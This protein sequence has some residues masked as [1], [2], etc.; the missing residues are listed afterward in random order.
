MEASH[1][2]D[3]LVLS[4]EYKE[5]IHMILT[6]V[7]MPGVNGPQLIK[8]C[9]EVRQDFSVIYMSG[10][11]DDVI[12]HHGISKKGINYIQKPFTMDGLAKKVREVLNENLRPSV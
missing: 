1:G 11:T 10:Y 8:Q 2:D 5:P 6:D 12:I 4:K 7:V 9:K 3:A